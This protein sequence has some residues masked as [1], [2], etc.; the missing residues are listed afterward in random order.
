M[1]HVVLFEIDFLQT[2][3]LTSMYARFDTYVEEEMPKKMKMTFTFTYDYYLLQLLILEDWG[4][5][6]SNVT[7][8]K[9]LPEK[10][11]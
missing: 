11:N 5:N 4:S 1:S 7:N 2:S 10:I 8:K 3:P 6:M 9:N